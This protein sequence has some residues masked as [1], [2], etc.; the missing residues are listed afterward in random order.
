[1]WT[2]PTGVVE[3]LVKYSDRIISP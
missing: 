3:M 2:D 1:M